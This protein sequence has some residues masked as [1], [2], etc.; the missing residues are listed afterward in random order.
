MTQAGGASEQDRALMA[1][2]AW[3]YYRQGMTQQEIG[4]RLGMSRIKVLRLLARARN[5]GIVQIRIDHP[6]LRRM[7]L[8]EALKARFGLKEAVVAPSGATEEQNLE[9]LG[10]F[11]AM[12]LERTVTEGDVIGTAWGVTLREVARHL[13]P[14]DVRNVTVVQLMGG[15]NAGGLVTPLDIARIVAEKLHGDTRMLHTPAFVDTPGIRDALLSDNGIAQTLKAGA[16]ATKA[17]VGI[18][19]VSSQC[20]LIRWGALSAEELAEAVRLGAVG[21]ILGRHY[22][23]DGRPVVSSLSGRAIAMPLETLRRIPQVIAVAGSERKADAIRGA[24]RGGYVDVLVTDER[25]ALRVL[26]SD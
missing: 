4:D 24:L 3:M 10:Q 8:E 6:S 18:G 26:A 9:A 12:Y 22:D 16:A 2:V 1:R 13:R 5:E 7:E 19:D 23:R 11:G 15:L 21:D 14:K 17:L 25:T 20:S